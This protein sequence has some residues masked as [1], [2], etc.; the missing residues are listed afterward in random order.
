MIRHFI[1]LCICLAMVTNNA[2]AQSTGMLDSSFGV[3][4]IL[5][6]DSTAISGRTQMALQT[7]GRIVTAFSTVMVM[8]SGQINYYL[9][10][11][12]F[13]PNGAID[14]SFN[15]SGRISIPIPLLSDAAGI[16]LQSTGKIVVL[17]S[18]GYYQGNAAQLFR[19]E[20]NGQVDSSLFQ[21]DVHHISPPSVTYYTEYND[22][23]IDNLDRIWLSGV[24]NASYPDIHCYTPDGKLDSTLGPLDAQLTPKPD[25]LP[26]GILSQDDGSLIIVGNTRSHLFVA[27]YYSDGAVDTNFNPIGH[28]GIM[29]ADR[30]MWP[31]ARITK[32]QSGSY[33]V[34]FM[35]V[36]RQNKFLNCML[37][38][39]KANGIIDSAWGDN[40]SH[41][42]DS[43]SVKLYHLLLFPKVKTQ[44]DG[45]ILVT[46]GS[47]N[48]FGG[49][50]FTLYRLFAN[51]APDYT[52]GTNGKQ[53]VALTPS[54]S[55]A[56]NLEIQTDGKIVL[57][58]KWRSSGFP[59]RIG[60]VRYLS[61]VADAG[62]NAKSC[63]SF[64]LKLSPNPISR[65]SKM[66]YRLQKDGIVNVDVFSIDG[67][68]FANILT[69]AQRWQG[70][71]ADH[72]E[73]AD[74]WPGGMYI[75]R[76]FADNDFCSIRFL[77]Q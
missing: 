12:R 74:S 31:W 23:Q 68:L 10:I 11:S 55:V 35:T 44:Y 65:A 9:V 54:E 77:K 15:D 43:V 76:L 17:A 70:A 21:V 58:G 71:N 50:Q 27:R 52:F 5:K 4:G 41:C 33:I 67:K 75:L 2:I 51:G 14:S 53:T 25:F 57:A 48:Q 42:V 6:P 7:D 18:T 66:E 59:Y 36:D 49:G 24:V 63:S 32:T 47:S 13:L 45:K 39:L 20:K 61:S 72:F 28:A 60:L 34:A 29:F 37:V 22:M 16:G 38:A 8:I 73:I 1:L 46:F 69:R 64:N 40:G 62:N 56:E 19:L 26:R 30:L 3:H